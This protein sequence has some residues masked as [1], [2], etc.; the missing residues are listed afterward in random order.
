A[1]LLYAT[2]LGGNGDDEARGAAF[3]SFGNSYVMGRTDS[4]NFPTTLGAIS[5]DPDAGGFITKLTPAGTI[6]YSTYFGTPF[7]PADRRGFAV[8]P[9]GNAYV[10]GSVVVPGSNTG[11]D[12]F[13]TKINPGGTSIIYTQT[14]RAAKDDIGKAIAVDSAGN[15]YVAGETS[16]INFPTN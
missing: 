7:G 13:L 15:A 11:L 16:S 6:V 4:T 2:Y 3:D 8:D 5:T 10:T 1:A 12:V 14:I 9:S